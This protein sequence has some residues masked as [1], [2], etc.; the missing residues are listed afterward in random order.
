M[1]ELYRALVIVFLVAF[2]ITFSMGMH[3]MI[4]YEN[5]ASGEEDTYYFTEQEDED[6]TNAYVEGDAYNYII[7]AGRATA[8]FVLSGV[9]LLSAIGIAILSTVSQMPTANRMEK[10]VVNV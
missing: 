9:S 10:E 3:K 5:P 4:A 7:N 6:V 8:L 2:V 1:K